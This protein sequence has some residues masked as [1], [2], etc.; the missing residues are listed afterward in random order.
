MISRLG[1]GD[2]TNTLQRSDGRPRKACECSVAVVKSAEYE[3]R[4]QT[5][6]DFF[7]SRMTDLTQS[8][9]LEETAADNSTDVMLHSQLSIKVDAE[10]SYDRP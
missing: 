9:Q 6:G 4:D 1:V 10:I 3:C 2:E 8:P 7:A 5:L